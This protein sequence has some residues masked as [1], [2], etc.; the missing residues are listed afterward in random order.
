MTKQET[1]ARTG[2][3]AIIDLV[4]S[5]RTG[6]LMIDNITKYRHEGGGVFYFAGADFEQWFI[7]HPGQSVLVTEDER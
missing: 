4:D 2:Y 3:T 5:T 1:K 7:L 6:D